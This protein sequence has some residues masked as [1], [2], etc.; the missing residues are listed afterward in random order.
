[1]CVNASLTS[2]VTRE[3]LDLTLDNVVDLTI[4]VKQ[5]E[6]INLN[7]APHIVIPPIPPRAGPPNPNPV[8]HPGRDVTVPY[9]F[10]YYTSDCPPDCSC[11]RINTITIKLTTNSIFNPNPSRVAENTQ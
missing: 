7:L 6:G 4:E 11:R 9:L 3:H 10:S 1:M 5:E 8:R 2:A